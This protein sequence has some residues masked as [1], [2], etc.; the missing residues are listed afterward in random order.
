MFHTL[1]AS[2][3]VLD[4]TYPRSLLIREPREQLFR[5]LAVHSMLWFSPVDAPR[6]K[7]S[8]GEVE[9]TFLH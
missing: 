1:H 6:S 4:H 8:Y 7:Y 5:A 9:V 2:A 3:F